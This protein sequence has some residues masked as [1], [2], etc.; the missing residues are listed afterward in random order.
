MDMN[1]YASPTPQDLA[2]PDAPRSPTMRVDFADVIR[3]WEKLR[4][5]YN[6]VLIVWVL[7]LTAL[8]SPRQFASPLYWIAMSIGGVVANFFYLLGP[9]IEGY[10]RFF[11]LWH[12]VLTWLLFLAGLAF[13]GFLSGGSVIS[14]SGS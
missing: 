9:A 11:R 6:G 2:N 5:A 3:R 4:L 13:T 10:G 12:I 7:A 8:I 1:P 14:L